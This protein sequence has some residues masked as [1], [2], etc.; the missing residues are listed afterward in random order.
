M[1]ARPIGNCATSSL[2]HLPIGNAV[3]GGDQRF[4]IENRDQPLPML[5]HLD[6]LL[7]RLHGG[8]STGEHCIGQSNRRYLVLEYDRAA[9]GMVRAVKHAIDRDNIMNPGKVLPDS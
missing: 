9:L 1:S 3:T 4:Q 5:Q 8:T 6:P 2:L 7:A